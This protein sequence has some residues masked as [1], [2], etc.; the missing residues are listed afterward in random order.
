MVVGAAGVIVEFVVLRRIYAAPEIFPAAGDLRRR[1]DHPGPRACGVGTGRAVRT[2]GAR[3]EG[4]DPDRNRVRPRVQPADDGGRAADVRRAVVAVPSHALGHDRACR[5]AGPRD[6][7]RARR[8]RAAAVHVGVCARRLARR[9]RRRAA[10]PARDGQPADGSDDP[11]RGLRRRRGRRAR[12]DH[13]CLLGVAGDRRAACVRHLAAAAIHAGA[14]LR[15]NGGCPDR[16]SLWAAR[17]PGGRDARRR[18]DDATAVQ[19]R[20][21]QGSGCWRVR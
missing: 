19:A 20:N 13:R 14:R 6:G 4:R 15:R 1:T 8:Q 10:D 5:H 2:A 21:G 3:P 9:A 7:E 11:G 17:A 16:A 18:R 12:L